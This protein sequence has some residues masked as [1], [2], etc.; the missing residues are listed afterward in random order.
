MRPQQSV[1]ITVIAQ[2]RPST[3]LLQRCAADQN[4][5]LMASA[6]TLAAAGLLGLVR[7][8][9]AVVT[10]PDVASRTP[11]CECCQVRLD[12][13]DAVRH[14]V[15][16]RLPPRRLILVVD[17]TPFSLSGASA[18]HDP[19]GDVVTV[20]HTLQSESEVERL[21]H[22]DGLVVEVDARAASTRMASG[23]AVWSG[24]IESA[25][26]IAD[27]VVVTGAALLTQG[28]RTAVVHALNQLNRIGHVSLAGASG[29]EATNLVDL[30]AWRRSPSMSDFS[31][32]GIVMAP[33][34][35]SARH[36]PAEPPPASVGT[37]VLTRPGVLDPDATNAWLGRIVADSST[38]LLRFQA[39]LQVSS[40][41][42]RVCVQGSRSTMRSAPESFSTATT[43]ANEPSDCESIVM[44]IGRDLDRQALS[45]SFGSIEVAR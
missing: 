11:G 45:E 15:L 5:M 13:I 42:P 6:E 20:I 30:D 38:D 1:P 4:S 33:A 44:L 23:S 18:D 36:G 8:G 19:A 7:V 34:W 27:R 35:P 41:E 2:E 24:Q 12:L 32:T 14:A 37:I 16:R 39:A 9:R 10:A 43:S 28:A 40:R 29:V 25:L 26:A 17:P 22:L 21:G 3:H 31:E